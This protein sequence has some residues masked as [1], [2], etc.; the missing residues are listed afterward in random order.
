MALEP[1]P[2]CGKEI[3]EKAD[4]CPHCGV[5]IDR[6]T[7]WQRGCVSLGCAPWMIIILAEVVG[8]FSSV[9]GAILGGGFLPIGVHHSGEGR[10]S[11]PV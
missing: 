6:T 11:F 8:L 2:E 7:A 4:E 1:C 9:P 5:E 3:G 10:C